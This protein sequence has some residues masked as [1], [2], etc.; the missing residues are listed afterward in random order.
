MPERCVGF[1]VVGDTVTMVDCEVPDQ[2][3][4]PL[5]V[6]SD[7]TW[8]LQQGDRASAYAVLHQRATDYLRENKIKSV[9][10]KA[11]ALPTGASKLSILTSAEVRGVIISA[12]ATACIP[13][14]ILSKSVISRTY[15]ERNVDDYVRDDAFWERQTEG[16]RLRKM[17]REAA[18]L[19]VAVRGD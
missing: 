17:S 7:Q 15:G 19:L 6:F 18:M 5:V 2:V 13:V 4:K 8:K 11:S 3:E 9:I 10:V 12:S 1:V 14:K 16:G